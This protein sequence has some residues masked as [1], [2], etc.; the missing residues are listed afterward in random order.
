MKKLIWSAFAMSLILFSPLGLAQVEGVEEFLGLESE[1]LPELKGK[2][3]FTTADLNEKPSWNVAAET[4]E[5]PNKGQNHSIIPWSTQDPEEWLSINSWLL[6][7]GIKDVTPDWKIR[8]RQAELKELAGKVLHCHGICQIY[9]GSS[10]SSARYLSRLLEGDEIK[11][12][13]NSVA[14]VFLMDGTLFRLSPETSVSLYEFNISKKEIFILARLNQGHIFWH[15]RAKEELVPELS[16][17]TDSVSLPLLVRQANQQMFE[18]RIF[19]QQNDQ[20]HLTQ[21]MN[22]DETAMLH[23]FKALN[24]IKVENNSGIKLETKAMI[25]T[26]NS[27][28]VS[29]NVSF[30]YLYLPGGNGYFKK[31]T[32][33][34]GEEFSL[35][36]RGYAS[37]GVKAISET[38]WY[39][40]ES[41]GR[42][43][44]SLDNVPGILQVTELLTK[45]IKTIE[46]AREIWVKSFTLP[47]MAASQDPKML[48]Q[49]FGYSL[50]GHEIEKRFNFLVEYTRRIETSNL[51]SLENLLSK[52]ERI[53]EK[54]R[55]DLSEDHYR[56]SL[57]HYLLG[58]KSRYD[59]K[60][61]RVRELNDLQY[62]VWILRNGKI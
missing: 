26:P 37:S 13:K 44:F 23:Q 22:F 30:D 61:M 38:N 51:R 59:N 53:G 1:I 41:N 12:G 29:Q 50:W 5:I 24:Q 62:Y 14:W 32:F 10:K 47:I 52:L 27:T 58:L 39:Q 36:L 40:V 3:K 7:R 42:S 54:V 43:Y 35:H 48:A 18:R 16:P 9:R 17:E 28:I 6:E 56:V 15:G 46:L 60:Q 31:R 45:R 33:V 25:V 55:R 8:L 49:D 19:A 20:G 57:N 21:N 34:L 11:T 2:Q 4:I